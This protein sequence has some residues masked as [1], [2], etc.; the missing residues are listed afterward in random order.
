MLRDFKEELCTF[1]RGCVMYESMGVCMTRGEDV[2]RYFR[3]KL[4]KYAISTLIYD[5]IICIIRGEVGRF[6]DRLRDSWTKYSEHL[7]APS[8]ALIA[9]PTYY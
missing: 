7:L 5:M 6:E 2:R 4:G 3:E 8:G 9:I 1:K